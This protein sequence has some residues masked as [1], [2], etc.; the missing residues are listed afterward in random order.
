MTWVTTITRN[1]L[2]DHFRKTKQDRMTDSM[3]T[4][5]SDHE[6]AHAPERPDPGPGCPA[7]R[8][9]AEPGG[10]ESRARGACKSFPRSSGKQ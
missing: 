3:D 2:V 7:G 4:T 8:Q 10:L 9:S 6:D 5:A 1:L